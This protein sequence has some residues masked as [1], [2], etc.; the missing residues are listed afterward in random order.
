MKTIRT[1]ALI[2]AM[3]A[4]A[5]TLVW[6]QASPPP[7]QERPMHRP[8]KRELPPEAQELLKRQ[9]EE[10][11]AL[12]KKHLEERQALRQKLHQERQQQGPP[13]AVPEKHSL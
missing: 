5:P 7:T 11:W 9:R 3:G 2:L 13:P 4:V 1:L 6:A 8:M 12:R 10:M